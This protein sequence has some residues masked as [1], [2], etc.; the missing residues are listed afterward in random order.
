MLELWDD[1]MTKQKFRLR[2]R[3]K[4]SLRQYSK[5]WEEII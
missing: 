5:P 1:R 4:Y 3:E 2:V